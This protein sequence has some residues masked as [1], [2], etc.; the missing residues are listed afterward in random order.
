MKF[1]LPI[2]PHFNKFILLFLIFILVFPGLFLFRKF[3]D[4]KNID[5]IAD[6]AEYPEIKG[7]TPVFKVDIKTDDSITHVISYLP[8]NFLS[9]KN[10]HEKA[11]STTISYVENT[12]KK[13]NDFIFNPFFVGGSDVSVKLVPR[14]SK[15]ADNFVFFIS[16]KEP[17]A[18][19]LQKN[20]EKHVILADAIKDKDTFFFTTFRKDG[21]TSF[22]R[23]TD[24]KIWKYGLPTENNKGITAIQQLNVGYNIEIWKRS[25]RI[26]PVISIEA[27][28]DHDNILF[29]ASE[30]LWNTFG[31]L[32]VAKQEQIPINL[33]QERYDSRRFSKLRNRAYY[34]FDEKARKIYENAQTDPIIR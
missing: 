25:T 32:V 14:I 24:D 27:I 11:A 5:Q 8:E 15:H 12:A 23:F 3:Q 26:T 33:L 30:S 18:K 22:L 19:V 7:R 10:F 34:P 28:P 13:G 2:I 9:K 16:D 29:N 6:K 17:V 4:Q 20:S 21:A 31:Q 1:T